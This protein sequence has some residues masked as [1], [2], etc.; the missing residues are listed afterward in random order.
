MSFYTYYP[1]RKDWRR[2]YRFIPGHMRKV[3]DSRSYD[4]SC[5]N[6]QSCEHCISSRTFNDRKYRAIADEELRDFLSGKEDTPT[7]ILEE[8]DLVI[9]E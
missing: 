7:V 2:Q 1:K 6:N 3:K 9:V 4:P 5:R 8:W